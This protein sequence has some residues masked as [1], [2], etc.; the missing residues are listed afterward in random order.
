[1]TQKE[2]NIAK[3]MVKHNINDL[4]TWNFCLLYYDKMTRVFEGDL[5]NDVSLSTE[6]V[7]KANT[8]EFNLAMW[9]NSFR[10]VDKSQYGKDDNK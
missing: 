10:R 1:M 3:W 6:I 9:G 5:F 8:D 4:P 7:I 2:E